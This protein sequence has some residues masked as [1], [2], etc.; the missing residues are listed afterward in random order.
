[1]RPKCASGGHMGLNSKLIMNKEIKIDQIELDDSWAKMHNACISFN[2]IHVLSSLDKCWEEA[3]NVKRE[4][5]F[6]I[7]L[8]ILWIV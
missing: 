3:N 6:S 1:M 5:S 7:V 4:F 8:H 2:K